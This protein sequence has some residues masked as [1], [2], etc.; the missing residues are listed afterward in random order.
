MIGLNHRSSSLRVR[1]VLTQLFQKKLG[2]RFDNA[3]LLSTCNRAELYF[4]SS[5]LSQ[6]HTEV[7]ATLRP[8]LQDHFSQMLYSFFGDDCFHHLGRVIAG[9]DSAIFGESEIQRQVKSAYEKVRVIK[10]LSH[11]LHFLF[12]K[13]LKIGKE[14]R[15]HTFIGK[16]NI[17]LATTVIRL[18]EEAAINDPRILF[19]GNSAINRRL[20]PLFA[21]KKLGEL[22]L[23]TR[24]KRAPF[25]HINYCDWSELNRWDDYPIVISG[26]YHDDYILKPKKLKSRHL[27]F[28]LSVP[29]NIDPKLREDPLVALFNIDELSHQASIGECI[30]ENQVMLCEGLIHRAVERQLDIFR[31]KV[32]AKWCFASPSL[33]DEQKLD[34]FDAKA[35]SFA[36]SSFQ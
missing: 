11:E 29:R 17:T 25:S 34:Y 16:E 23:C 10:P 15:T 7:L 22:T 28:D 24:T 8:Y 19:V 30:G 4:S 27:L 31:K 1:E 3:V 33:C 9:V 26:T 20:I 5:H 35:R 13:S 6:T 18:I 32:K 2:D 36:I 14:M 21:Q 12:Q